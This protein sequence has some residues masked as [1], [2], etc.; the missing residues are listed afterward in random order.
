MQLLTE[1]LLLR[2]WQ[3]DDI[4][5]FITMNQDQVVMRYFPALMSDNETIATAERQTNQFIG[6][7]GLNEVTFTA[8]FTPA[9]EI[10]WRLT[11]HAHGVGYATEA[12]KVVLNFA[13]Q[14]TMLGEI[15][16]STSVQNR[17]SIRVM[18]KIGLNHNPD[19]DFIHPKLPTD[20][21]LAKHVLYPLKLVNN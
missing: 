11:Q 2:E 3:S 9:I 16:S 14:Q 17:A 5:P 12:A 20:H 6:F 18:E 13:R 15:V 4:D 1:R 10:G 8:D 7:V 19:D 21:H